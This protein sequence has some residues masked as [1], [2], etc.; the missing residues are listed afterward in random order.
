[1][2][3]PR[4]GPYDNKQ[5]QDDFP[6]C[7]FFLTRKNPFSPEETVSLSNSPQPHANDVS[8]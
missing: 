6:P 3:N 4:Q 2:Q 8:L 7:P 1:M 5:I